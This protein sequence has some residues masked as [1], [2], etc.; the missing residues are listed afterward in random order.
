MKAMILAAGMGIRLRPYTDK[1][2]KALIE[3]G[4]KTMLE[5]NIDL[6]TCNG[7]DE[8]IINIHHLA[9]QIKHFT[10]KI[11][12]RK[13]SITFSEETEKLL[14]TGGGV[15]NV[16]WFFDRQEPFVV[17]NV[18]V[19]SDLNLKKVLDYHQQSA[20]LATLAVRRR[21]SSRFLYFNESNLLCGW[22]NFKTGEKKIIREE[23]KTKRFAFSGIQILEPSIFDFMPGKNVFSLIE[24][25]LNIGNMQRI[26]GFVDDDSLWFDIG[27]PE[28]LERARKSMNNKE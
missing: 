11:S 14:D 18:D 3:V 23:G 17:I 8:I 27:D 28:K 1:T 12:A 26:K 19:L 20:S 15:K 22:E 5:H 4:G 9:E 6:L 13:A 7:F 16:R 25:Y 10:E 24:L 2:P 21:D